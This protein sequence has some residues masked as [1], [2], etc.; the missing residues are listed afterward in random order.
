MQKKTSKNSNKEALKNIVPDLDSIDWMGG[1]YTTKQKLFTYYYCLLGTPSYH[2]FA[3][4][5]R[6]AGCTKEGSSR[7]GLYLYSVMEKVIEN[8][9]K[10][11]KKTTLQD[12]IDKAYLS[13]QRREINRATIP[14][15]TLYTMKEHVDEDG[16]Q[17][18]TMEQRPLDE[19]SEQE[20]DLIDSVDY[21]GG[22]LLPV[23]VPCDQE[24]AM[25]RIIDWYNEAHGGSGS[26]YDIQLTIDGIQKKLGVKMST[27]E[28]NSKLMESSGI[29]DNAPG[30]DE[31]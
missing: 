24:K 15:A 20:K 30:E 29:V 17:Y 2:N 25:Q 27:I 10:G 5:A 12:A 8:T 16:V 14:V 11:V 31:L 19:L 1:K 23:Y 7:K 22:A 13:V 26:D 3:V 21:K 18:K 28:K 9:E 6:M 4:A